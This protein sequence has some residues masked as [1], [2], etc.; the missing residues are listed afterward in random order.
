MTTD[1]GGM[2]FLYEAAKE[3][4]ASSERDVLAQLALYAEE[5]DANEAEISTLEARLKVVK[6]AHTKLTQERIPQLLGKYGLSELRLANGRKV[7]VMRKVNASIKDMPAFTAFL[8]ERGEDDI[9]KT[10]VS[11]GKLPPAVLKAIAQTI[12]EKFDVL[13][14]MEH[15]IHAQT[16]QKWVR[17]TCHIG[18]GVKDEGQAT[19]DPRYIPLQD[20]PPSINCFVYYE[21]K[22]TSK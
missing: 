18:K 4:D 20:L 5:Y 8:S 9:V 13:P 16:L 15:K 14:D 3:G 1:N 7:A 21:T 11:F 22:I 6:E 19:D 10:A 17:E 12:L 2:D